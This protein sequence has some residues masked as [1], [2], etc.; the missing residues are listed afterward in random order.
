[1]V[2]EAEAKNKDPNFD[3]RLKYNEGLGMLMQS[4]TIARAYG[5]H[6]VTVRL[7]RTLSDFVPYLTKKELV[8]IDESLNKVTQALHVIKNT[9]LRDAQIKVAQG[10]F[11]NEIEEGIGRANRLIFKAMGEHGMLLPLRIDDDE[12][13]TD[14]AIAAMMGISS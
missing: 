1:M 13:L 9:N 11:Q 5:A 6:D 10:H 8:E 14:E 3:M 4:L 12:E 7:L 2:I